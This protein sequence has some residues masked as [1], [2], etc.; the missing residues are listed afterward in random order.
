MTLTR[1]LSK[2]WRRV[3]V[4]AKFIAGKIRAPFSQ[5]HYG[6]KRGFI[7]RKQAVYFDDTS[8]KDEYQREVYELARF[9]LDKYGYK[10]V[11]DIG[12]GSGYKLLQFFSD[13]DTTG[14]DVSPTYEFLKTKYPDRNWV[15]ALEKDSYPTAVDVIICADVIEHLED[16]D[17]LM[18]T[19]SKIQFSLL[20][21]STP[22]RNLARGWHDYGPPDNTAHIREWSAKELR[23]YV[24][25]YFKVIAHQVTNIDDATQLLICMKK[26][27][28]D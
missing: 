17:E 22:E 12:C 2:V 1:F 23:S 14:I 5:S 3:E 11:L 8:L 27:A 24:S 19:M 9:Y 15:N 26:P 21:L 28:I 18:E 7:H 13:C 4:S 10:N 25:G 20:F 16:P 6:I